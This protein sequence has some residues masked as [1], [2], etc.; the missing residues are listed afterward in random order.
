MKVLI[1]NN[2]T[3][4][5]YVTW[6]A[7][8]VMTDPFMKDQFTDLYFLYHIHFL[9]T[10]IKEGQDKLLQTIL[11]ELVPPLLHH[12]LQEPK[13]QNPHKTWEV[14]TWPDREPVY[15]VLLKIIS[16]TSESRNKHQSYHWY[17]HISYHNQ[18]TMFVL[19]CM[20]YPC[21]YTQ[22]KIIYNLVHIYSS[23]AWEIGIVRR[24]QK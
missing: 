9:Y 6:L 11:F 15:L 10:D 2:L 12:Y 22:L 21:K 17:R 3:S 13:Q 16:L 18:H 23:K 19:A 7:S 20:S 1:T 14:I 4:N 24:I 5:S 8:I